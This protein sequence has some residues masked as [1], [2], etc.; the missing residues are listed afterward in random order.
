MVQIGLLLDSLLVVCHA[1]KLERAI[2]I[3]AHDFLRRL[4]LYSLVNLVCVFF[5]H[6]LS[7]IVSIIHWLLDARLDLTEGHVELVT[8]DAMAMG[9]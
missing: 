5:D 1:V 7:I 9:G 3:A 6:H 8:R 4:L 2:G